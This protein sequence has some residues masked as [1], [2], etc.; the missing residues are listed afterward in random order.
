MICAETRPWLDWTTWQT[1]RWLTAIARTSLS[2][3]ARLAVEAGVITT[4]STVLDYG[5]GRGQDVERL[6]QRGIRATG[7]DAYFAVDTP[8]A[9]VDVVQLAFVLNVIESEPERL[10]VL[11]LCHSLARRSLIVAVQPPSPARGRVG[12]QITSIGTF[13]KY[14]SQADLREL[15]ATALGNV[16]VRSLGSGIVVVQV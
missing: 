3:P 14:L 9:I 4:Q 16:S 10:E 8:L 6:T 5:C 12:E 2:Q 15:I 13:Q 1:P 11:Q 7:F